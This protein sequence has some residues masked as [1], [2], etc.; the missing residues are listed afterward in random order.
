MDDS[1]RPR[2]RHS[3]AP[4]PAAPRGR[5]RRW[6]LAGG[7]ALIAGAGAGVG[8]EFLRH[9]APAPPPQPPAALLGAAEAERRLIADLGA[10]TGG[11]P[12][13]QIVIAQARANHRAH[14]AALEALLTHYRAPSAS[15]SP[16]PGTPRTRAQ[17]RAAETAAA[18]AA[19]ARAQALTGPQ[20]ALL[21][22][23][24]ACESTHAELLA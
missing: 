23:I 7:V 8:A 14:L 5:S 3:S 24:A 1:F 2:P 18:A 17:L 4:W 15:A 22:S 12:E 9:R 10:T 16:R 21:A 13:V 6:F 19:A 11:T 20:A